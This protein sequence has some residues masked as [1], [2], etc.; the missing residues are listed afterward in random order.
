MKTLNIFFRLLPLVAVSALFASCEK[1]LMP[2]D[3]EGTPTATFDYLWEKVDQQYA[4][5]DV[6]NV[7]WN[8]VRDTLRPLVNDGMADDSLFR[9]LAAMLNTLDDGHVNIVSPFDVSHCE[10]VYG[11]MIYNT[12]YDANIVRQH[13]LRTSYHTTGAFAWNRIADG[14]VVYIRYGSFTDNASPADFKTLLDANKD[15]EA[16]VLDIRQNGGGSVAYMWQLLSC[17]YHPADLPLYTSQI[18]SG[19][20]HHEFAD[21]ETVTA[22]DTT[23]A[24]PPCRLPVAVL[25]DRGTYSAG[26][27]F[28]LCAKEYPNITV[29]GD[30]TGG[31]LG[32]PNGGQLPN[33]WYYRFSIT[34]TLSLDGFNYENGVPPDVVVRLIPGQTTSDN[35]IEQA[36]KILLNEK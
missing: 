15:A 10:G 3:M 25:T 6:K 29:V 30:T 28:A 35:V 12:N 2:S 21:V 13:Y 23:E 17:F 20:A 34:R 33:G 27:F 4:F 8:L 36:C 5:F 19:P 14:R 32:L 18:K 26:S 7:D 9:V 11:R 24:C 31:G 1:M 16:L 22:P